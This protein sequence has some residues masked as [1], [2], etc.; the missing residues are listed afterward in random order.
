MGNISLSEEEIPVESIMNWYEDQLE[1][2]KDFKNKIVD[3]VIYS[4]PINFNSKFIAFTLEELDTYFINS[5]D[6]LEHL[7][8][9]NLIAATE[10]RLRVDFINRVRR[11]DKST[12]G[13]TFRELHKKRK[14]KI[15]LEEHIIET[16]K[17]ETDETMFS[18]FLGI[19]NYR[20]W[21]AHGRY[22]KPKLGRTY[23]VNTAYRISESIV[24]FININ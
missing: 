18:D 12:V 5:V 9:F 7:V 6:E 8:C 16:W 1:A 3:A 21:M 19:L 23:P 15:S 24:N 11:K 4:K 10:A 17:S 14:N 22:W 13:R 20:H 2:I